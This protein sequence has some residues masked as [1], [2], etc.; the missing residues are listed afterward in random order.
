MESRTLYAAHPHSSGGPTAAETRALQTI[1]N[2]AAFDLSVAELLHSRAANAYFQQVAD[3]L[4][5]DANDSTA[6][7]NSLSTNLGL[8]LDTGLTRSDTRTIA[9]LSG[10]TGAD[11]DRGFVLADRQ[12]LSRTQSAANVLGRSSSTDIAAFGTAQTNSLAGEVSANDTATS[13]VL[14]PAEVRSLQSSA[15]SNN[16]I[17]ATTA[18]GMGSTLDSGFVSDA[19]ARNTAA[20]QAQADVSGFAG[21]RGV[22]LPTSIT[23]AGQREINV[24]NRLVQNNNTAAFAQGY[25]TLITLTTTSAIRT[26]QSLSGSANTDLAAF[27]NSALPT[28]QTSLSTVAT[29]SAG[30]TTG[31][32]VVNTGS[33]GASNT[34]GSSGGSSATGGLFGGTGSVFGSSSG[35]V[36]G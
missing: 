3:Q 33:G 13:Q 15:F 2:Q 19:T 36:F 4:I 7:L 14:S 21:A 30:D 6:E 18:L 17:V 31:E 27:A 35:S 20:L 29:L 28:L 22:A 5:T 8:A 34:G 9:R 16:L 32:P 26:D 24:L 11:F 23:A 10:L 12:T 1:A 25:V